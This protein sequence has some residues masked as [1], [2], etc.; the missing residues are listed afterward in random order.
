MPIL[1][2]VDITGLFISILV[3]GS[4]TLLV[5]GVDPKNKINRSFGYFTGAIVLW[6][7]SALLLRMSL[8]LDP[9]IENGLF[10]PNI[11]LWLKTAAVSIALLGIFSFMFTVTYL[12][13]RTRYTDVAIILGLLFVILLLIRS[14]LTPWATISDVGLDDKGLV[15]RQMR[16]AGII[17]TVLI[18]FYILGS[19]FLFFQERRRPEIKYLVL[20]FIILF[21]ALASMTF[22]RVPFPLF[23]F[24][25]ALSALILAYGVISKQIFNPLKVRTIELKQQ[26]E[27][28][29]KAEE[30]VIEAQ[31]RYQALFNSKAN[32]V[33]VMNKK[34]NFIDANELALDLFGYKK[35]EIS[36]L[37][38]FQLIHPDQ[39]AGLISNSWA[40]LLQTGAQIEPIEV[41]MKSRDGKTIY[42]QASGTLIPGTE[43]IIGVA[44]D[45]TESKLAGEAKQA[46]EKQLLQAQ[47]MEAVGT[48]AGGI[49]HDFNNSLQGILGFI[50]ILLLEKKEDK[51]AIKKFKQ[52]EAAAL[53]A[54]ELTQQLLTFSR[55]VESKLVPVDLNQ[56][57][58]QVE[59]ILRRTIPKMIDIEL[60]L[61]KD[62]NVINAD[63]AQIEQ[64]MMNLAIN[65]RDAMPQ[66]G[67]LIIETKNIFLD[68]EYCKTYL[69][70]VPGDYA[71]LCISD[72]GIGI[73][74]NTLEYIFDPFFTTKNHNEGT[75]LGLAMVYG[76]IKNHWGH[77][78]CNSEPGAGTIFK[79]YFPVFQ[80]EFVRRPEQE[81]TIEEISGGTETILLVDD[82]KPIRE[83]AEE[84]LKMFGYNVLSARD[85][86]SALNIYQK[87]KNHISLIILDLIMPGMGGRKCLEEILKLNPSQKV[88][89]ASGYSI[90]GSAQ[91][92]LGKGAKDFIKKPYE[93][94]P[95]LAKVREV[96]DQKEKNNEK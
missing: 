18:N 66:G 33:F 23:S 5:V 89:I 85:G 53:R 9:V 86:E 42:I 80:E 90:N 59:K 93:M 20:S 62:L 92:L 73:D 34:G 55:Q 14:F 28:R 32:L 24:F 61:E 69:D 41:K 60:H 48:L 67:K 43:E 79:I 39:N 78:T 17:V 3:T 84:I 68:E 21:L 4:L 13:R 45:I 77:I 31:R 71:M 35:E 70:A 12:D 50:Q 95:M 7:G 64:V 75:G 8:W 88:I 82:D 37:T 57:A 94:R 36:D 96:L 63:A 16:M 15:F 72:N 46:L 19:I 1:F 47:K 11:Y 81:D 58:R 30:E 49:A 10:L 65:A 44:R 40:E 87:G 52:I 29:K 26:I 83:L 54:S 38:Y 22:V 51:A 76:I 2:W 91:D 74:N 25:N 27:E 56:E 6:C